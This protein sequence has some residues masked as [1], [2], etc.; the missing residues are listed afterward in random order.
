MSG[1]VLSKLGKEELGGPST[2]IKISTCLV[3]QYH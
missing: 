3:G 2:C 1:R